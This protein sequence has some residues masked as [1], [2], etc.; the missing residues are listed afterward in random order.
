MGA[1]E[2]IVKEEGRRDCILVICMSS[3]ILLALIVGGLILARRL[4]SLLDISLSTFERNSNLRRRRLWRHRS[5]RRHHHRYRRCYLRPRAIS[6]SFRTSDCSI[7]V[8]VVDNIN[9]RC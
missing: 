6:C 4:R 5:R 3:I 7:I 1:W 2:V 8:L 9:A